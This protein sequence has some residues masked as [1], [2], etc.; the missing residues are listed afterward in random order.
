MD[1][2]R[3]TDTLII[4]DQGDILKSVE[5]DYEG[6]LKSEVTYTYDAA[7]GRI[8]KEKDG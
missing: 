3:L 1:G 4:N 7:N 8:E 6:K 5:Y 2:N